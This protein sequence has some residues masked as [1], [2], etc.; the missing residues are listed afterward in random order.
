MSPSVPLFLFVDSGFHRKDDK[1]RKDGLAY[2]NFLYLPRRENCDTLY[3]CYAFCHCL[4]LN[5]CISPTLLLTM[6]RLKV[7]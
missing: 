7:A 4:S 3:Q 6:A 5:P 2:V 1:G